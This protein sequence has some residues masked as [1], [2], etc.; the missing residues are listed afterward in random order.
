[1][2]VSNI[3]SILVRAEVV[4]MPCVCYYSRIDYPEGMPSGRGIVFWSCTV[5]TGMK[6]VV[7]KCGVTRFGADPLPNLKV[8]IEEQVDTV[9]R[10]HKYGGSYNE[11][12]L[13]FSSGV[14]VMFVAMNEEEKSVDFG[15]W[16]MFDFEP[17]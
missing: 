2:T 13:E 17:E 10:F 4:E 5:P 7:K 11:P 9:T 16:V 1:M 6:L 15:A 12:N 8:V 14:F 3:A